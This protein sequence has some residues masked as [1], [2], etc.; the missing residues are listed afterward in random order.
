MKRKLS[1]I[2]RVRVFI[3]AALTLLACHASRTLGAV[4]VAVRHEFPSQSVQ[5]TRNNDGDLLVALSN[6]QPAGLD[7]IALAQLAHR[8][9]VIAANALPATDTSRTVAVVLWREGDPLP[10]PIGDRFAI[11]R[12]RA[13]RAP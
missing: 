10:I 1:R 9:A 8:V 2:W 6:P 3:P 4:L 11:D 5:V 12:L 7:S 13:E